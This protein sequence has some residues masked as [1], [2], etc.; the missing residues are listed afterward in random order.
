MMAMTRRERVHRR[1]ARK[2]RHSLLH[3]ACMTGRQEGVPTIKG[4]VYLAA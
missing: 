1:G 3:L 4:M 2:G